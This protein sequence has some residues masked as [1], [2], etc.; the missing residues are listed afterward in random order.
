MAGVRVSGQVT[1]SDNELGAQ[2]RADAGQRLDD[3]GLRVTA[4]RLADLLVDP[5]Q[6][7]VQRED[8]RRQVSHDLGGDVL[9]GQRR[10]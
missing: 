9:A 2:H 5:L 7:V 3:L 6:P 4:E 8:L 1:C 10:H